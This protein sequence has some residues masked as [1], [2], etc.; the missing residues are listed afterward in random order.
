MGE[1]QLRRL[2]E[3]KRNQLIQAGLKNGLGHSKTLEKSKELDKLLNEY[4]KVKS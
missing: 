1:K 2:I 4:N 3:Q